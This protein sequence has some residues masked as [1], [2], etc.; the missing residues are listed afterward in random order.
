VSDRAPQPT[1]GVRAAVRRVRL[2]TASLANPLGAVGLALAT[3]EALPSLLEPA[4]ASLAPSPFGVLAE[5]T[6]MQPAA[7]RRP[8][9]RRSSSGQAPEARAA[10]PPRAARAPATG[11]TAALA[12]LGRFVSDEL[13]ALGVA[14]P[15]DAPARPRGPATGGQA[16]RAN[17]FPP[18]VADFLTAQGVG[19]PAPQARVGAAVVTAARAAGVPSA[20]AGVAG[21]AATGVAS[22]LSLLEQL[23]AEG[24]AVL[25]AAP[26]AARR[27]P[28]PADSPH[29]RH[30]AA[31]PPTPAEAPAGTSPA[32]SPR[33]ASAS[34][35]APATPAAPPVGAGSPPAGAGPFDELRRRL[36]DATAVAQ[37]PAAAPASSGQPTIASAV[38]GGEPPG[39]APQ[40]EA[41]DVAWLVNE[42]LIEQ[43]RRHGVD[44]S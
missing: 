35:E 15:T 7:D 18:E 40:L 3:A 43:A 16:P 11:P 26:P 30:V 34:G 39:P 41:N 38:P 22:G 23:V 1:D 13:T 33:P 5:L 25:G 24:E 21:T 10:V 36:L 9:A 29:G 17:L 12:A 19:N 8:T 28:P 2:A 32:A 27:Q 14:A 31:L 20:V 44:L 6:G 42:A 37:A 4:L